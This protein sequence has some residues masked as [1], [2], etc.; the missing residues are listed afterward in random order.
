M[1]FERSN[2]YLGHWESNKR[3]GCGVYYESN[4][5]LYFGDMLGHNRKA[6]RWVK[7][8]LR[9]ECLVDFWCDC[10]LDGSKLVTPVTPE[11]LK[12]AKQ[13]EE[14]AHQQHVMAIEM[15]ERGKLQ[16]EGIAEPDDLNFGEYSDEAP[17]VEAEIEQ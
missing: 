17:K 15:A 6:G 1:E 5:H 7:C 3:L 11:D 16:N 10:M 13:A 4:F 12:C 2:R 9:E 8:D 14:K